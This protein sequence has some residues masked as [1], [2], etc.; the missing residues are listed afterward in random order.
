M[1]IFQ[2]YPE[3][4]IFY[5]PYIFSGYGH[6]HISGTL[7]FIK[8]IFR[9]FLVRPLTSKLGG[10]RYS[11]IGKECG[12][13]PMTHS[14]TRWCFTTELCPTLWCHT[15]NVLNFFFFFKHG[16][17][18]YKHTSNDYKIINLPYIRTCWI[19]CVVVMNK[20]TSNNGKIINVVP[21]IRKCWIKCGSFE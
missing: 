3:F 12:I 7:N 6:H 5:L 21:C 1:R 17:K 13:D 11:S 4:Q 10:T 18:C 15:I 8:I 14:I 9:I 2:I 19:Y 20:H 16:K